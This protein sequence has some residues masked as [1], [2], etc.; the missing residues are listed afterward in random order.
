[1]HLFQGGFTRNE[2]F[3]KL[4]QVKGRRVTADKTAQTRH[5]C[6]VAT[7]DRFRWS[8]GCELRGAARGKF[9]TSKVGKR[10]RSK[11]EVWVLFHRHLL[12]LLIFSSIHLASRTPGSWFSSNLTRWLLV[13]LL[14]WL[15]FPQ[16][17][18]GSV[19]RLSPWASFL[20]CLNLLLVI[21]FSGLDFSSKL[22][23][24]HPTA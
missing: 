12:Q 9:C 3:S 1:M 7:T 21:T 6:W 14:C 20:V 18:C 23:I 8:T 16:S 4:T 11:K 13:S 22:Q 17:Q 19:P 2:Y 5:V 15:L 24:F 10:L